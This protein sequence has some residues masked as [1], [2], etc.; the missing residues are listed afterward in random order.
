MPLIY[1]DSSAL[2]SYFHPL[3]VFAEQVDEAVKKIS[4]ELVYWPLLSLEVRHNLR[5]VRHHNAEGA[6]AWRALR[7]AEKTQARL[8]RFPLRVDNLIERADELSA[9][10]TP[11]CGSTDLLHIAAAL[12]IAATDDLMEFWTC[13]R[14]Q[15]LAA[16]EAGLPT[17]LFS[18]SK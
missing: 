8:Q 6:V 1:A 3:A 14:D 16:K 11:A 17:R 15:S 18:L 13:D 2:F 5:Q 4:P 12:K 9:Q 10:Y 7:A